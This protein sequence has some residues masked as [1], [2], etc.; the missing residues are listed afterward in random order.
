MDTESEALGFWQREEWRRG[1]VPTAPHI[2]PRRCPGPW[3][4]TSLAEGFD[5]ETPLQLDGGAHNTC[6]QEVKIAGHAAKL[7][8]IIIK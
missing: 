4:S 3:D 8:K 1:A 6:E 5:A 7:K 2:S